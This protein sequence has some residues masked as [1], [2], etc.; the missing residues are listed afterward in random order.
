[1]AHLYV[2]CYRHM[3]IDDFGKVTNVPQ[4]PPLAEFR[5][6]VSMESE[7]TPAFPQYTSFICVKAEVDCALAFGKNPIA[8]P[9]YHMVDAGERLF[10]GAI[11]GDKL[12]VVEVLL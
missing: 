1:M 5:V 7:T 4:T 3:T 6:I 11:E 12:A 2:T 8:D 10:Y 9:D